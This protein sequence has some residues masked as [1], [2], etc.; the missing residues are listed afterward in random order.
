MEKQPVHLRGLNGL[1]AKSLT[2]P[3]SPPLFS[4]PLAYP[5]VS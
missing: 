1:G 4:V 3:P 2:C 5:A